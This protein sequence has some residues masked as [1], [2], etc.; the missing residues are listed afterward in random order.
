M[1]WLIDGSNV[2]GASNAD[3]LATEPKRAL[4][5]L[6]AGFARAR[7]T[8][9]TCYFDGPEPSSFGRH[10]GSATIVFSR[11]QAADDLIAEQAAA[12][13]D[14]VVVTADRGLIARVAGRRIRVVAPR[15]FL[16]EAEGVGEESEG[17]PV[18]DWA[19][20]LSDPKNRQNF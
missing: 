2:L 19:A 4:A 13:R 10:L 5:A 3:P 20:W 15:E 16:A 17:K 12:M 9:V 11:Q 7:R 6:C 1:P 8:R 14:A 18:E